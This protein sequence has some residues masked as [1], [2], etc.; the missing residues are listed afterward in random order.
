MTKENLFTPIVGVIVEIKKRETS[1]DLDIEVAGETKKNEG[2][3]VSTGIIL[4]SEVSEKL[5]TNI[6]S[7]IKVDKK[8]KFTEGFEIESNFYFVKVDKIIGFF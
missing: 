2:T 1:P 7:N 5:G 4:S 6:M 8:I 3:I